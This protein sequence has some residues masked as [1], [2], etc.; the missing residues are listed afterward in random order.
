VAGW[1]FQ[2]EGHVD[3]MFPGAIVGS[4][5]KE[6]SLILASDMDFIFEN[7]RPE[8]RPVFHAL[9]RDA[10]LDALYLFPLDSLDFNEGV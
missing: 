8:V 7:T 5:C 6:F 3:D 4:L 2:T 1:G 10:A 9:P